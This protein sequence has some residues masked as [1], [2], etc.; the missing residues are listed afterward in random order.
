[1]SS[2]IIADPSH[3]LGILLSQYN[4]LCNVLASTTL[5]D[6]PILLK[7][8]VGATI[9]PTELA[10]LPTVL[11][12]LNVDFLV[13]CPGPHNPALPTAG[14]NRYIESLVSEQQGDLVYQALVQKYKPTECVALA[15][16][17]RDRQ[18]PDNEFIAKTVELLGLAGAPLLIY[19]INY[20]PEEDSEK[21]KLYTA[22]AGSDVRMLI[23]VDPLQAFCLLRECK[24]HILAGHLLPWW[25]AASGS[26]AGRKPK[27]VCPSPW[28]PDISRV[29]DI[30]S[31]TSVSA[32]ALT[33]G[34]ITIP[35]AW[36][37][38][39]YYD[40]AYYIN[41]DRRP[42][43]RQKMEAQLQKFH[44]AALRVPAID[45]TAIKWDAR[46]G[47]KSDFWNNGAMA[48]CLSYRGVIVDAIKQGYERILVMD[49]DAVLMDNTFQVLAAAFKDLPAHWH[50]L[51]LGANHGSPTPVAMPT[52][53]E[54]IGDHLYRL[55]GSVGS[56]AIIL[57]K[58]CFSTLLHFL[59]NPYMP[60]DSYMAGYQRFF[61]CY[62]TYPGVAAQAGGHSDIV[63]R[64]VDY[65]KEWGVDYINHIASRRAPAPGA[66]T[67]EPAAAAAAS[68][69]A[70]SIP[71]PDYLNLSSV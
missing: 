42:D 61:P 30:T 52:E 44:M 2:V 59:A 31:N 68:V 26:Q 48:Y 37:F 40:R 46:Y 57:H 60:L 53:K 25:A 20:R 64:A 15:I 8:P 50:M 41:L 9:L 11:G 63:G 39:P 33:L 69:A 45:G 14:L 22:Q 62:I 47:L 13:K 24:G 54:R 29:V 10:V 49:D 58:S 67:A 51:Y 23:H 21:L 65:A 1:M 38:S 16:N 56:H 3:D 12:T 5:P 34:W 71:V 32:I 43:R 6:T 7:T 70:S 27:V 35:C 55:I 66:S 4:T 18:L 17:C 28:S 36:P 19:A